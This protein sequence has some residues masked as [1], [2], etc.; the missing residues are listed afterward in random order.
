VKAA[1]YAQRKEKGEVKNEEM[2]LP[3]DHVR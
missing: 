2:T 1:H 3:E